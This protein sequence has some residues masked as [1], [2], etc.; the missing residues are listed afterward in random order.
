MMAGSVLWVTSRDHTKGMMNIDA[1]RL[2]PN[3]A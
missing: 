3:I 2:M 1:N